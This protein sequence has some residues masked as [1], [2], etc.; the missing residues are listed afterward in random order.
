MIHAYLFIT[1]PKACLTEGGHGKEFKE[2]MN[3]INEITKL[4]VTVYHSFTD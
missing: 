4:R 2:M 3:N 1:N